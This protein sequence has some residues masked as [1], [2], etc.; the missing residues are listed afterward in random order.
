M[1]GKHRHVVGKKR[2]F[3]PG[4]RRI[5]EVRGRS[6]GVFNVDGAY[7][8]LR[9]TCPHQGG[10]LCQGTLTGTMIPSEP[11]NYVYGMKNRVLRCP[12]HCWEFDITTGKMIFVPDPL[13]VKTYDVGIEPPS[14]ETYP[15]TVEERMV[16]LYV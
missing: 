2:E 14:V 7:Y 12:W 16:V 4:T 6:I 1:T 10:P 5:V 3:P 11:G 9:N 8:A 13:R 15:V